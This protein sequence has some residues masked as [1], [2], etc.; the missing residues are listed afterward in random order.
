MKAYFRAI[1]V[2]PLR[3][4]FRLLMS[5]TRLAVDLKAFDPGQEVLNLGLAGE[6]GFMFRSGR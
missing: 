2:R 4:Q 3:A 6:G 5:Y 1:H